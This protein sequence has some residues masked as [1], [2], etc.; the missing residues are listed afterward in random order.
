MFDHPALQHRLT[1][2]HKRVLCVYLVDELC[3]FFLFSLYFKKFEQFIRVALT[4]G[5]IS[6]GEGLHYHFRLYTYLLICILVLLQ[7]EKRD[8][9]YPWAFFFVCLRTGGTLFNSLKWMILEFKIVGLVTFIEFRLVGF[10]TRGVNFWI[11][12]V[13][14]ATF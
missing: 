5:I 11:I 10:H 12:I 13:Q 4:V 9:F 14:I 7:G 2:Y 8:E 6:S 3:I 1:W